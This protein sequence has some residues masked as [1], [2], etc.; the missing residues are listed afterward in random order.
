IVLI[1]LD[2][3]L[4]PESDIRTILSDVTAG[5]RWTASEGARRFGIDPNRIAI[6][7]QILVARRSIKPDP[8]LE[9]SFE[10]L[11]GDRIAE[12][13]ER[14]PETFAAMTPEMANNIARELRREWYQLGPRQAKT[15][16]FRDLETAPQTQTLQLRVKPRSGSETF[17]GRV[18]LVMRVNGY[19]F[20]LSKPLPRMS[21]DDYHRIDI[22]AVLVREG[23]LIIDLANP[24]LEGGLQPTI[25]FNPDDGIQLLYIV[26]NFE[27]N[28]VRALL[29]IWVRLGFLAIAALAAGT[30]LSFP[31]ACIVAFVIY[32]TAAG[33]AYIAESIEYFAA[34]PTTDLNTWQTIRW[35]P[36]AFWDQI[37]T[38]EILEA[39]KLLLSICGRLFLLIMPDFG[40]ANVTSM[41][42]DGINISWTLVGRSVLVIGLCWTGGVYVIGWLIFRRRELA[43]VIV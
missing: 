21:S 38:G 32:Y 30:F 42:A 2:Y 12:L 1:S 26:G 10:Q 15:F 20:P 33:S 22:P 6:E 27:M 18:Q 35:Y 19:P 11:L 14:D 16:V 40:S 17:D 13:R 3:R 28:L 23:E 41:L 5:L 4:A 39:I 24:P 7:E 8:Q 9:K 31:I 43:R 36:L 29:V 25:S 37:T 34:K